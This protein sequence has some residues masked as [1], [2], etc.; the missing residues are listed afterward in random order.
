MIVNHLILSDFAFKKDIE[1]D[2][3]IKKISK[4][5]ETNERLNALFL[6]TVSDISAVEHGIWNEWKANLLESLYHKIQEEINSPKIDNSLNKKIEKIKREIFSSLK[7]INKNQFE[8]FSKIT[9]PNYWLLQSPKE[10][11]FQ[12]ENFLLNTNITKRFDFFINKNTNKNFFELT[13]I[14]NDRP[15]LFLDLISIF[16][17]ENISVFEA[18][19]FTLDDNTVIDTF[20]FSFSSVNKL[21]N[22]EIDQKIKVLKKKIMKLREAKIPKLLKKKLKKVNFLK[23]KIDIKIDN[24]SSSTYTVMEVI[25]NDRIG[26]LYGISKILIKNNIIISMAKISTNGDFVEDSFHLRNNFGFKIK[27]KLFIEKLKKEIRSFLS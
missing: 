12:I 18:R 7:P 15:S 21:K 17:S 4:I 14:T 16:V 20:K 24:N 9:Y 26:L 19:I 10:I 25:T 1:D 11:K 22:F 27:D 8:R 5:I 2:S 3:I 6:L 23:K 13:L